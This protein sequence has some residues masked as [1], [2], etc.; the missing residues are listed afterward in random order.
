MIQ[1]LAIVPDIKSAIQVSGEGDARIKLDTSTT[2]LP[3]VLKLVMYTGQLLKVTIEA[4]DDLTA[5]K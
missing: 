1:F 4:E 3:E 2:E 5:G